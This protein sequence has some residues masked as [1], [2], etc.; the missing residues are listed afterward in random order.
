MPASTVANLMVDYKLLTRK[1]DILS[2]VEELIPVAEQWIVLH[3]MRL[4][5]T[6]RS[7]FTET[8]N[9]TQTTPYRMMR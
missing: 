8:D 1:D 2:S 4:A 9:S 5:L 7:Q 6:M 3:A